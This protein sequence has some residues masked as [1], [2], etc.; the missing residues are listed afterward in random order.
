MYLNRAHQTADLQ[1]RTSDLEPLNLLRLAFSMKGAD[2]FA[3]LVNPNTSAVIR[4]GH[5]IPAQTRLYLCL[6]RKNGHFRMREDHFDVRKRVV[7]KIGLRHIS[8]LGV[9]IFRSL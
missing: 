2:P 7:A 9:Q 8:K 1:L 4:T 5:V 6:V 3:T